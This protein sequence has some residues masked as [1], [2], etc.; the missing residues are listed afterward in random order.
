VFDITDSKSLED[1]RY[2]IRELNCQCGADLPKIIL[3]NKTDL[4]DTKAYDEELLNELSSE[5]NITAFLVSA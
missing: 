3:G 5:H 1:L 4:I 2:W